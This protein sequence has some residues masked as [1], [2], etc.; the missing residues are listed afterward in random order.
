M[1]TR[2]HPYTPRGQIMHLH[3]FAV[4]HIERYPCECLIHAEEDIVKPSCAYANHPLVI[5]QE[6][7]LP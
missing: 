3:G 1:F 5:I 2:V 7:L 4:G 6:Y